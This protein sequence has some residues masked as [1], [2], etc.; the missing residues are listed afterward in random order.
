MLDA[1]I[2]QQLETLFTG[3]NHSIALVVEQSTHSKQGELLE[4]LDEVA[5]TS[6]DLAVKQGGANSAVPRFAIHRDGKATGIVFQGIP[7]GHEFTS[8]VVALLNTAGKGKLPDSGLV[9]RIKRIRPIDVRTYVSLSC[10]SC[11]DIVQAFNQIVLSH[12]AITHTMIDGEHVPDELKALGIQGVPSVWVGDEMIH[13][14]RGNLAELIGKLEDKFKNEG[15]APKEHNLGHYVVGVLG[16]GPAGASAAIYSVRKGV[17]TILIAEK[18]GGQVQETKGIENLISVKYTEGPELAANLYK[19]IKEYPVE[20][21]EHRRVT[22]ITNKGTTKEVRLDSGEFFTCDSLI[23]ATGAKWRELGI[24]GERDYI[25]RGVAFCAHCDGPYYKA[26]KVAVIGGGNSG[27]EAAI[28][29][30]SI[31]REVVLFE[32]LDVLKADEVLVKKLKS[33]PNVSIV[34]SAKTSQIIGNGE[35]V[36]SLNYQNRKT[37]KEHTLDLDGIFVQIGLSPNS[38]LV[39]DLVETTKFGEIVVDV[40]GRTT[41]E[42]VYAAGDVT[43]VPYKQ[44]VIAMGEGAK[45]ALTA[46][47]DRM[48]S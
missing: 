19:H 44:I 6:S 43:T 40:K 26:K 23:V 4:M 10:E 35:K 29:L 30:A 7:G 31:A 3:L 11:P 13:S 39:K 33:L 16:G 2:K 28:D 14:G 41:T 32:Y 17:S 36:V 21:L 5:S 48:R 47:E 1:A 12:G 24:P 38:A 46:F 25:G 45:V 22:T 15:E 8:F 20:I 34:T 27:V 42:G 9:N 37:D 18:L